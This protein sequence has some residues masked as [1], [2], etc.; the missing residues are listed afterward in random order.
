MQSVPFRPIMIAGGK[1]GHYLI[2]QC[3]LGQQGT[4]QQNTQHGFV[5]IIPT[6]GR[7]Y[8]DFRPAWISK[9]LNKVDIQGFN[10]FK[11]P[12]RSYCIVLVIKLRNPDRIKQTYLIG[13]LSR[14]I[15]P[16]FSGKTGIPG[17]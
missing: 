11:S 4:V 12:M 6:Q 3:L 13:F 2:F 16:L 7:Q 9:Q 17:R 14:N 15:Q 10:P 5:I 1:Q 8:A